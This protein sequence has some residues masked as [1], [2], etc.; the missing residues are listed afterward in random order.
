VK[1]TKA[2]ACFLAAAIL[3]AAT[4]HA[5]G[6]VSPVVEAPAAV[7]PPATPDEWSGAY[8]GGSLGYSF[9]GDDE[10]GLFYFEDGE[11]IAQR[12]GLGN[13]DLNGITAGL[14]TGYRWQ[15]NKWVFGPEL[16]IE[17]GNVDA[18]HSLA[19]L[20]LDAESSVNYIATLAF[21]AGYLVQPRTLVYGSAGVSYG[22]FDYQITSEGRSFDESYSANGYSLGLGAERRVSDR[23]SI[24]AEWQYRNFGKTAV[25]F[26]DGP[27]SVVT[28]A[29]PEHQNIKLGV[30]FDF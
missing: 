30:N 4:A 29:T 11:E 28:H 19:D 16:V 7:P 9:A 18:T 2:L 26:S 22:D 24:F 13:L 12:T 21:K 25:T 6:F 3:G 14:H 23:M 17:G 10:V 1:V 15:R 8:V 5:G 20:G 27:A